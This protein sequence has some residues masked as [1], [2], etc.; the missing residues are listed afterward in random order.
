MWPPDGPTLLQ[1]HTPLFGALVELLFQS[2]RA[3]R[4]D[5]QLGTLVRG[6]QQGG[7]LRSQHGRSGL[8]ADVSQQPEDDNEDQDS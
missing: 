8:T 4:A 2:V 5:V 1:V 3:G 6:D 7:R